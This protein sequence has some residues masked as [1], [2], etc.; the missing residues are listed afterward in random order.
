MSKLDETYRRYFPVIREKCRR[1]L[2][3]AGDAQDLAQETFIRFW[4]AADDLTDDGVRL[5]WIYKTST[6]LAVDRLRRR[7]RLEQTVKTLPI[8]T[9]SLDPDAGL[10]AR[11]LLDRLSA[12]LD[13]RDLEIAVLHRFDRMSQHEIASVLGISDRTVRRALVRLDEVLEHQER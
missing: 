11:R 2:G 9:S 5:A 7:T 12:E 1:M 6:H 4:R 13:V 3:D 8:P 10:D